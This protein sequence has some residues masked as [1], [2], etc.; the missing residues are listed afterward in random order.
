MAG[1]SVETTLEL[2]ASSLRDV[3]TRIGLAAV[4]VRIADWTS[5]GERRSTA[6]D[7]LNQRLARGDI[8]RA[9]YEE[10]RKLIGR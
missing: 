8:D 9:E 5:G 3:K 10:K 1:A 4:I 6:L 2:W 7:S